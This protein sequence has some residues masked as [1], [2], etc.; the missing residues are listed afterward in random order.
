MK[1]FAQLITE[2]DHTKTNQKLDALVRYFEDA[3]DQDKLWT[4]ALFTHKRPKRQVSTTLLREWAA[5]LAKI[6]Q[7]LF[8]ES[9]H[10]T[11]DLAETIALVL[12]K[13]TKESNLS[14]SEWISSLMSLGAKSE[15]EK[16][17]WVL[18]SWFSLDQ[19]ER[20][21][22]NKLI[23][24]G[25]RIGVSKNSITNALAKFLDRPATEIAHRLMGKWD[26]EQTAF[27]DLLIDENPQ[28]DASKPYPF[29]QL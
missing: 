10:I 22:F 17:D 2:L 23:T 11:G 13:P 1:R 25:W 8:D 18:S 5:E 29:Y 6:P 27:T 16:K 3:T 24:G 28:L 14:L 26:P 20:F 12:P 4:I 19:R 9:Y 15:L 7:W 21:V